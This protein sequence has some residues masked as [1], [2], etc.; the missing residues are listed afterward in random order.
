MTV[1]ARP[2]RLRRG[3]ALAL[4]ALAVS[5]CQVRV[6]TDVS[7]AEDGSGRMAVTIA[8]DEEL[9]SSLATDDFD[10]F[11]GLEDLPDG[12][13]VERSDADGGLTATVSADFEDPAGLAARVSQLGEG[14]DDEDPLLFDD[15]ELAV[16]AD[17]S[18]SFRGRAGFRP[19]SSTGLEG[20]GVTFDGDDLQAMLSERGDEVMR[21]DLRVSMPG[22]VVDSDA[23]EVDGSTATWHLPVTELVE[24]RAASDP[25]VDRTWWVV[26][27]AAAAGLVLGFLLVGVFRRRR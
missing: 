20:V 19:P 3:L 25:P 26:G 2:R 1:V 9:A 12:W 18:A 21:V 10:P 22:P 24:V 14:V 5:A 17:G 6:G 7:V 23:D 8:L 27:G 15:V 11:A 13:S 16:A 4:V